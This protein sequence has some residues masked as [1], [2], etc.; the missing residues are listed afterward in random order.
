[1]F[2]GLDAVKRSEVIVL[3]LPSRAEVQ[4]WVEEHDRIAQETD[5]FDAGDLM[6]LK[7]LTKGECCASALVG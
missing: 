6:K 7:A 5:V 3:G 1:M 2:V 4:R